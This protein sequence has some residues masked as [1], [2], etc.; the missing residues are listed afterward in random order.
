MVANQIADEKIAARDKQTEKERQETQG[1]VDEFR[2]N[3]PG[4]PETDVQTVK[5]R[6]LEI[7]DTNFNP[8]EILYHPKVVNQPQGGNGGPVNIADIQKTIDTDNGQFRRKVNT[9]QKNFIPRSPHNKTNLVNTVAETRTKLV[10][11]VNDGNL[12]GALNSAFEVSAAT[13]DQTYGNQR[14]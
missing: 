7:K 9:M 1:F 11:M 10:K 13:Q 5:T 4:V 8:L 3:N 14:R 6:Y 2:R 12:E